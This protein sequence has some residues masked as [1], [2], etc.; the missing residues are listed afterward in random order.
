MRE[1]ETKLL[2]VLEMSFQSKPQLSFPGLL[3]FTEV[4]HF[5][6]LKLVSKTN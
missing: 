5:T 6:P 4:I 3:L 1:T 2:V